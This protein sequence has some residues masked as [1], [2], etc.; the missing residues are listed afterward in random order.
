MIDAEASVEVLG[1]ILPL[2][3]GNAFLVADAMGDLTGGADGFFLRDT[4]MLSRLRLLVGGAPP[5]RLSTALSDDNV[6]FI[7]QATNRPLPP[8]GG[9]SAPAGIIHIERR[10]FLWQE[11]LYERIRLTNHGI[12]DVILPLTIEYGADYRDIFEVRGVP[13]ET[14]GRPLAPVCD[15]RQVRFGY[16]GL[17]GV[18]RHTCLSF[19]EPPGRMSKEQASFQLSLSRNSRFDLFIEAGT[20]SC[21]RP[22]PA[23]WRLAAVQA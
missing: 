10:R 13:R 4:R 18:T 8:M 11:R 14:R 23:R 7:C 2:K 19:S 17:D 3:E 9:R 15:G 20:E 12:D 5:S 1:R 16:E 21:E 22:E 6:F